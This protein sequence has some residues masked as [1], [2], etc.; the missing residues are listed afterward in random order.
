MFAGGTSVGPSK[1]GPL[2]GW[3]A[4]EDTGAGAAR[5]FERNAAHGGLGFLFDLRLTVGAA[6]PEGECETFLDRL[7]EGGVV[8]WI[9]SIRVAEGES[10]VVKRLL[11]IHERLDH[12]RRQ[13]NAR[14]E[15]L[16]FLAG[17]VA[18]GEDH[19]TLGDI[20]RAKLNAQRN[21]T[22]L[23]IIELEAGAEAL[24]RVHFHAHVGG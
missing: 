22:H 14:N 12:G 3:L 23:P 4:T 1:D 6:A 7:L 18:P 2:A 24:A 16:P 10:A 20:L 8:L 17:P 5:L 15:R 19:G 9:V 21:A 11:D 13:S